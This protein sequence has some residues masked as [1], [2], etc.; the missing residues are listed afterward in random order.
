MIDPLHQPAPGDR[1]PDLMWQHDPFGTLFEVQVLVHDRWDDALREPPPVAVADVRIVLLRHGELPHDLP[2]W[3]AACALSRGEVHVERLP[4]AA[5][6]L[7]RR[8]PHHRKPG[9]LPEA[10]VRAGFDALCAPHGPSAFGSEGRDILIAFARG[11][12]GPLGRLAEEGRD[13]FER[14]LRVCWSTPAALARAILIERIADAGAGRAATAIRRLDAAAIE[15]ASSFAT[16]RHEREEIAARL[17]PL[18]YFVR[19]SEFN[20]AVEDAEAWWQRYAEAYAAHYRRVAASAETELSE[21]V[22]AMAAAEMLRVFNHSKRRGAPVGDQALA[23]LGAALGEIVS[24]ASSPSSVPVPEIALGGVPRV[25]EEARLAAAAVLA[26][27]EV[28]RRRAPRC[29]A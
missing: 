16:L 15:P 23:H 6:R 4:M 28:Q 7:W 12:F 13:G 11:R 3:L 22:A 21:L 27:V 14:W 5:A 25:F 26:A 24:L 29:S 2:G 19:L 8:S 9:P 17:D 18:Q 1:L 10:Y 20:A